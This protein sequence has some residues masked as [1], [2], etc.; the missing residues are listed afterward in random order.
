V[1]EY[2]VREQFCE[3]FRPRWDGIYDELRPML[4]SQSRG[5][6]SQSSPSLQ[7]PQAP[8]A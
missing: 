3:L 8:Q 6:S 5:Q 4:S 7:L 1:A 2:T